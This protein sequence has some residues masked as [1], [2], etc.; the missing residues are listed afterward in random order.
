MENVH[1]AN[2]LGVGEEIELGQCFTVKYNSF[3]DKLACGYS[4][5]KIRIYD[6]NN[7]S[8]ANFMERKIGYFPVTCLRWKPLSKT[9][10]LL[11]NAN[12]EIKQYHSTSGKVLY[13]TSEKSNPLM[14]VDY[15]IHGTYFATGGND[16]V[17][18]LY[19]DETKTLISKLES[20]STNLPQHVNRIFSVKFHPQDSNLLLSGGWDNNVLLYDIRA[21]EVQG[22]LFGPHICGDGLD[23]KEN[24]VITA[25]GSK[26]NQIMIFDLKMRKKIG[27]Y[28]ATVEKKYDVNLDSNQENNEMENLSKL[29][30]CK[31]NPSNNTFTVSG[32]NP[33]LIR[34]YDYTK[35]EQNIASTEL[36]IVFNN[37]KEDHASYCCDIRNDGK[38]AVFGMGDGKLKFY[39]YN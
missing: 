29:Y 37:E 31:I 36:D 16:K 24:I 33:N 32:S 5:G 4:N 23:A 11:V 38:V 26:E 14:C 18:K 12:G 17:V 1:S 30:A 34:I 2:Q 6:L 9:I 8:N 15:S 20:H 25:S 27:I 21:K 13:E 10:I 39:N 28:K 7:K 22:F 19:D 35:L 3:G